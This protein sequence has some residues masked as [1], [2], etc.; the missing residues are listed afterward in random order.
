MLASLALFPLKMAGK[1]VSSDMSHVAIKYWLAHSEQAMM[2]LSQCI[3]KTP[4]SSESQKT[5]H[6]K[7]EDPDYTW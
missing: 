2:V 3:L 1:F 6:N 7:G 4:R 5:I